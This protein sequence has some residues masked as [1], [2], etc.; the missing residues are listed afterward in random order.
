MSASVS[1][2]VSNASGLG[3]NK[4]MRQV[5]FAGYHIMITLAAISSVV[6]ILFGRD[7]IGAFTNDTM[8]IATASTLVI[9]LVLYQLVDATQINFANALRGTSNVMPMLWIALVSYVIVGVP[10][11]YI[12][13]IPASLGIFG[14]ILSFSVPLF[15]AAVLFIYF[16]M[17]T[18]KE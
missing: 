8:V 1:V 14:I 2:L 4:G 10:V 17:K 15:L 3:D 18:T 6:F 16:F 7:L 5:A 9:P 13:A 12:L 11:T